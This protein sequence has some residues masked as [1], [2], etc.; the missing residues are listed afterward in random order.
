MSVVPVTIG[1][2]L[3]AKISDLPPKAVPLIKSSLTFNNEERDVAAREHVYGWQAMPKTIE[4]WEENGDELIMPRGFMMDLRDG[5]AGFD[6]VIEL[7]DRRSFPTVEDYFYGDAPAAHPRDYQEDAIADL[8]E[9]EHGFYVAPTG[10]GKTVTILGLILRTKARSL[11]ITDKANMVDQWR[12]RACQWLG[13]S[14]DLEQ[15]DSVGM[16]AEGTWEERGV[17]IALRQTLWARLWEL[18]A[19]GWFGDWGLTC[20]DEGHHLQADTLKEISMRSSSRFLIGTSATPARSETKK[21]IVMSLV[22]PVAHRTE[23]RALVK[24][25]ILVQPEIKLVHTDFEFDFHSTIKVSA[26]VECKMKSC[27]KSGKNHIHRSNWSTLVKELVRDEVRNR[28]I[29]EK[30]VSGRGHFQLVYSRQLNHLEMIA[31]LANEVMGD[32]AIPAFFLRGEE[33][34]LGIASEII[35][36]IEHSCSE[37]I[38]YS[39]L[40][41]EAM[42][43]P[44]L[45]TLHLVFPMRE[46]G[47]ITQVVGRIERAAEG[48]SG[49]SVYDYV[50]ENVG[51]L[52]NQARAR[53]RAYRRADYA[54]RVMA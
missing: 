32:D 8:L 30:I 21:M 23:R 45:D 9:R 17:T 51:V 5:L 13:L 6:C 39:T 37:C 4:L 29:A 46:E 41:N 12:R 33:N 19:T 16:I 22:G 7:E 18:S 2:V 44:I 15:H 24:R 50:D 38:V 34:R 43:I 28:L 20:F 49:A 54:I 1:A 27:K 36:T 52:V 10:A 25:G 35:D 47:N 40:A 42:D 48:K 3:S 53:E 14:M 31:D 11:I 26:A